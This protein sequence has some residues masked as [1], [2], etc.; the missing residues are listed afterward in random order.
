MTIV[1]S[2]AG[3]VCFGSQLYSSFWSMVEGVHFFWGLWGRRFV[4]LI[5]S[6][7]RRRRNRRRKRRGKRKR[8]GPITLF[9]DVSSMT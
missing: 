7:Y 3:K 9:E 1:S 4:H 6:N 2:T 8:V 5:A